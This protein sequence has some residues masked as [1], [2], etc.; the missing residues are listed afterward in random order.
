LWGSFKKAKSKHEPSSQ[1]LESQPYFLVEDNSLV[2][3]PEVNDAM[4]TVCTFFLILK[5]FIIISSYL[6]KSTVP[7]WCT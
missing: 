4:E 1:A 3:A 2:V 7:Q 5:K 6:L